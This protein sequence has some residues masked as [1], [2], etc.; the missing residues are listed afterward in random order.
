V[1]LGRDP[2]RTVAKLMAVIDAAMDREAK[3]PG[4]RELAG[5]F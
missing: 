5:S 4:A 3:Q 2:Q 1:Q